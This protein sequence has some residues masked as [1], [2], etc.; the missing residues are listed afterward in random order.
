MRKREGLQQVQTDMMCVCVCVRES[1]S[2]MIQGIFFNWYKLIKDHH[3]AKV[4][5]SW[6][7]NQL[8]EPSWKLL[9]ILHTTNSKDC[10]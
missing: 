2:A 8:C 10:W 9:S 5:D 6:N 7:L 4:S 3:R 1:A